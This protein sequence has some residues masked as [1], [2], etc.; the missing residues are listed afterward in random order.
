MR[1]AEINMVS[2]GSTGRIMFHVAE[3]AR[4]NGNTVQTYSPIL[5]LGRK[6]KTERA[7]I[8]HHFWW[9]SRLESL[10]HFCVGSRL[11]ANGL[12]SWF[13]TLT[14]IRN[15]KRLSPDIIHIHNIHAFCLNYPMFFNYV[16]KSGARVIWTFHDCWPFTGHCPHFIICGCNKW[17]TECK[18]C[19]QPKVYPEMYLDTSRIMYHKKKKWFSELRDLTIVTPSEW[20][21]SLVERSFFKCHEVKVINNGIDLSIFQPRVSNFKEK[22]NIK[23]KYTLL[24][25]SSGWGYRKGLDV[26]I[27]LAK[28]LDSEKYQIVL[29]GTNDDIDAQLPSNI[30]SIH[31]TNDQIELAEIYSAADLFVNPTR[32]D[33]YPTVNMESIACGTPVVTF[34]TGGS[35]EIL[36]QL[37]GSV[38]ECNDIDAMEKEIKRVTDGN[39]FKRDDCIRRAEAFDRNKCFDRYVELFNSICKDQ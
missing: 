20:L 1:I 35:P 16:K 30:I 29:V 31:R 5:F 8:P 11:G 4:L 38:V 21:A 39:V 18:K 33:T 17:Q 34:K 6:R 36:D 25:V 28:R 3:A 10:F 24:G 26:F 27:E 32:E 2:Y 7:N 12:F 22:Y 15:L 14:L 37:T 9:G 13:G 23:A 19:P